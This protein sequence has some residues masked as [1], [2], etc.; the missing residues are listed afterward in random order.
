LYGY[1]GVKYINNL[2]PVHI[3]CR[4]HGYFWQ[5]PSDHLQGKGCP[6]CG[7]SHSRIE[8]DVKAF[9]ERR[10]YAVVL[11]AKLGSSEFDLYLPAR[12]VGF[13][14]NGVYWHTAV[15]SPVEGR[16]AGYSPG[17][18]KYKTDMAVSYGVKL[19]HLWDDV[20]PSVMKSIIAS[21]LGFSRKVYARKLKVRLVPRKVADL[22]YMQTHRQGASGGGLFDIGLVDDSGAV[23]CCMQFKKH[24]EGAELSR[25]SSRCGYQVI[26]GLSRLLKYSI[27]KL[28]VLGFSH[29][30]SYCDRDLSPDWKDTGYFKLGFKFDGFCGLVLSYYVHK[31]FSRYARGMYNRRLFQ[32]PRL[33]VLFPKSYSDNKTEHQILAENGVYPV[34]NSGMWKF[35][36][37][38]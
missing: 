34:Y 28:K 30:V 33:K 26:G 15:Y 2:H 29:V 1:C 25:F 10:N 18:H 37:D 24:S 21:K 22:F 16:S 7:G 5:V 13:E 4:K 3:W 31:P 8:Y 20:N 27:S 36:L 19:Y 14:F 9:L 12:R 23:Q 35:S 17:Y 38:I 6:F 11:G 32:K